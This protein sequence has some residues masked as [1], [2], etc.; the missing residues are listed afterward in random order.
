MENNSNNNVDIIT[1]G[2]ENINDEI[3]LD[4]HSETSTINLSSNDNVNV[5]TNVDSFWKKIRKRKLTDEKNN[6][7]DIEIKQLFKRYRKGKIIFVKF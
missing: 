4:D 3:Q 7:M 5:Q 1:N 6:N 2:N